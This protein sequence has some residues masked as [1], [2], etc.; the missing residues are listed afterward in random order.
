MMAFTHMPGFVLGLTMTGGVAKAFYIIYFSLLALLGAG[1]L[2][3]T[4]EALTPAIGF[5]LFSMANA[6]VMLVPSVW[7][8]YEHAMRS[9]GLFGFGP[10][11]AVPSASRYFGVISGVLLPGVSVLF[12]LRA[13]RT[14]AAAAR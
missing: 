3:R 14:P 7:L 1:L 8:R 10:A 6:L 12:L 5:H 4:D 2:K 9:A 13:R 11:A